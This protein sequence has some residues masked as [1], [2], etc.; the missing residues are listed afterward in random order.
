MILSLLLDVYSN[1]A[2]DYFRLGNLEQAVSYYHRAL[3]P[4]RRYGAR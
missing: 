4:V 2:N 3:G 1:L